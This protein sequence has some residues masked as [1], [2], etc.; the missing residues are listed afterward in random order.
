MM[1]FYYVNQ[2]T[3]EHVRGDRN[4]PSGVWNRVQADADGWIEWDGSQGNPLP[5]GTRCDARLRNRIVPNVVAHDWLNWECV[6]HYRPILE[7][8]PEAPMP[9]QGTDATTPRRPFLD[10][11]RLRERFGPFDVSPPTWG[12]EG[13]PP[14]GCECEV[15]YCEKWQR[16][17]IIAHFKQRASMVA[18]FTVDVGDGA[19][20]FDAFVSDCFRPIR[21]EEDKA[22]E[23]MEKVFREA[24]SANLRGLMRALYRAGY[25]KTGG[26]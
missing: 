14:V 16:C 8:K 17:E 11:G 13:L 23:E 12:G 7:A 15:M 10:S 18:A 25:R 1:S 2:V 3:K 22:V 21:S 9:E 26:E 4:P 6:T 24:E 5:D 20:M 19:K